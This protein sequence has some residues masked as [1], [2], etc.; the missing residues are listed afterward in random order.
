MM[1]KFRGLTIAAALALSLSWGLFL[2][3]PAQAAP[4]SAIELPGEGHHHGG[5]GGH[6]GGRRGGGRCWY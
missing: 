3:S 5:W 6:Q 2:V 1:K 4:S